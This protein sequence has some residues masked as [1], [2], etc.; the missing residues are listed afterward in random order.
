MIIDRKI[1]ITFIILISTFFLFEFT[2]I[3]LFVE[4]FFYDNVSNKWMLKHVKGSLLDTV[5]YTGVK[6]V[7]ILFTVFILFLYLYSFKAS[8][9]KLKEYRSGLLIVWLSVAIVPFV[10]GL[11]KATT[12]VPCPCDSFYFGG[13]YPYIKALD[14]MPQEILKKFKCYPAGHASGGF[15]LMSLFFLFKSRRN[16][17]LALT[18]ALTIGWSMGLYKMFLGD[19]YLSHTIITMLLSWLLILII[20]KVVNKYCKL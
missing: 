16:K 12:N 1:L 9:I 20:K 10:I 18:V 17:I 6:K 13:N 2:N 15:A 5:F 14:S 19:H 8:A 4:S 11:L 7:I 3:D